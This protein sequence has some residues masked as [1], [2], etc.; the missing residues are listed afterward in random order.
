[1]L[2]LAG[3]RLRRVSRGL[4]AG[5]HIIDR[6]IGRQ[7][8]W[9]TV[10]GVG[11]LSLVL[12]FGNLFKEVF[13]LLVD[14]NLP[15]GAVLK[16][17][18][19]ILPFSL[20]FT[21]PWGFLTAVLLVFGRLSADNELVSLRMAGMSMTRICRPVFLIVA[22]LVM[23]SLWINTTIAPRAQAE[24]KAAMYNMVVDDPMAL[25]VPDRVIDS[26]PGFAIYAEERVGDELLSVEII[27]L[28]ASKHPIKYLRANKARIDYDSESDQL[29]LVLEDAM[30]VRKSADNPRDLDRVEPG[31][32]FGLTYVPMDLGALRAKSE[33]VR[34]S[35]MDTA[36][37]RQRLAADHGEMDGGLRNTMNTEINKRYSFSLACFTF[38][39]IGIPLGVT[40]QRRETS[41][42]FAFSL[43]IAVIYFLFIIIAD[44]MRDSSHARYLM[45][46]PNVVFIGIG[47][48]MFRRMN[49]K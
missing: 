47:L 19:Y 30:I 43:I 2:G 48:W 31:L 10:I 17:M 1:M 25:F 7:V 12:V 5:I 3:G 44:T 4:I 39:L 41:V 15:L 26:F 14:K 9:A 24:M 36:E 29:L 34:P 20:I 6:Y 45:W 35:T 16:F 37:L 21:I 18:A 13:E 38:A 28:N 46:L 11:V 42:G 22:A 8:W 49:K 33:K 23:L 32:S 40:A 27:E